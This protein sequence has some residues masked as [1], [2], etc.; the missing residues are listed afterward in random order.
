MRCGYRKINQNLVG[1]TNS[2]FPRRSALVAL[3][4]RC[5]PTREIVI[6]LSQKKKSFT[7]QKKKS[8]VC[9][10]AFP[11][12]ASRLLRFPFCASSAARLFALRPHQHV[13]P[14]GSFPFLAVAHERQRHKHGR[15]GEIRAIECAVRSPRPQ[16]NLIWL[17]AA[18][19]PSRKALT[20]AG[21]TR[22]DG[23]QGH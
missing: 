23:Q 2:F 8:V 12:F 21:T 22:K 3:A 5:T 13:G 16:K 10:R 9:T 11:F 18:K 7:A 19:L 6:I 20:Q 15:N 14:G 4:R 1:T 17:L